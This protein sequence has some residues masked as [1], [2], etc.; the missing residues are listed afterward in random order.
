MLNSRAIALKPI[1]FPAF[2]SRQKYMLTFD[3]A[4][5]VM[6]D[7]YEDYLEP[8]V[9]LC[10][11]AGA[12]EGLAHMTIDEAV[13]PA[14][15][16]QRRPGAHVDGCFMPELMSWGGHPQPSWNHYCNNIPVARMPVIVAASVPGCTVWEGS[17]DTMPAE[18]GDLSHIADQLINGKILPANHGFL[19]SPDCVHDSIIFDKPTQRQFMRIA[20]PVEF[21]KKVFAA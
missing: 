8:A 21:G 3:L 1:V 11:A 12:H 7:G 10:A 13:I 17:F 6:E 19:L 5:P 4:K 16:S 15:R 9:Q 2:L 18:G 14:G 20:L